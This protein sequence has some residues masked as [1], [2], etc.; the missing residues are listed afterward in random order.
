MRKESKSVSYYA[1]YEA[2]VESIKQMG[3][4]ATRDKFNFDNPTGVPYTGSIAGLEYA[5]GEFD[6]LVDNNQ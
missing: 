2:G 3:F 5:Y 4:N 6:A 1:G